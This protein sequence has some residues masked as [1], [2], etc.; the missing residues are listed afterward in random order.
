MYF[1]LLLFMV[2]TSLLDDLPFDSTSQALPV[3]GHIDE[4]ARRLL[5]LAQDVLAQMLPHQARQAPFVRL[6]RRATAFEFWN[7]AGQFPV[8][9]QFANIIAT[10]LG[11]RI[12]EQT[13]NARGDLLN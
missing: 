12:A 8:L 6:E 11:H 2:S 9:C 7:Q 4:P 1:L 3:C 5:H 10:D 13:A